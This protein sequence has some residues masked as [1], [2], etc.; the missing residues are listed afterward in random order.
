MALFS[1]AR[2]E[3]VLVRLRKS[4][5]ER[6]Q[7][8][9]TNGA[10]PEASRP[11]PRGCAGEQP[12]AVDSSAVDS[13]GAAWLGLATVSEARQPKQS[14]VS[15]PPSCWP[16]IPADTETARRSIVDR[17]WFRSFAA[18]RPC[19]C[20]D[21]LGQTPTRGGRGF[22]MRA[23]FGSRAGATSTR[24]GLGSRQICRETT[25]SLGRQTH[26]PGPRDVEQPTPDQAQIRRRPCG[27]VRRIAAPGR[28]RAKPEQP[29][30]DNADGT[31]A[32]YD[33]SQRRTDGCNDLVHG[34]N[35][36][37][38]PKAEERR[39]RCNRV[40][41]PWPRLC[42]LPRPTPTERRLCAPP[43]PRLPV[44]VAAAVAVGAGPSGEI[45]N[46]HNATMPRV[47]LRLHLETRSRNRP[48]PASRLRAEAAGLTNAPRPEARL[49]RVPVSCSPWLHAVRPRRLKAFIDS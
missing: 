31:R 36:R 42:P 45:H 12:S 14:V 6:N 35:R 33:R 29:D 43:P 28:E 20:V 8:T 5:S 26:A 27:G 32:G 1:M 19:T 39:A 24:L 44:R 37:L 22:A 46:V 25:C 10:V 18:G 3:G 16:S 49:C 17:P 2:S 48:S 38:G 23:A 34:Q 41:A 11:A 15:Y 7:C 4:P 13:P 30:R 9:S 40:R 47:A 21:L